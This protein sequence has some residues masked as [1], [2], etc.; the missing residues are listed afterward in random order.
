MQGLLDS[1]SEPVDQIS[2][3]K[4]YYE[5]YKSDPFAIGKTTKDAMKCLEQ[6]FI[7]SPQTLDEVL[8]Q[9]Y[10][11]TEKSRSNGCLMRATPLS[12][13]LYKLNDSKIYEYT[14]KEVNLTHV[15][16]VALYAVV[17][18]NIAISHLLSNLGDSEGAFERV[19]TF[20]SKISLQ[21]EPSE[22]QASTSYPILNSSNPESKGISFI[23]FF[24]IYPLFN[25][26]SSLP[27][28]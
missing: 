6:L 13:Y 16:D 14:K 8:N 23:S 27:K 9:I 7:N 1:N 28:M 12:V 24:L 19:N 25:L 3:A 4:M 5:W 18:Y 11:E 26:S 17:C 21:S 22:N 20:I 10:K 15:N 2:I